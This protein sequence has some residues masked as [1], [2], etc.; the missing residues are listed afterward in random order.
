M[1][2][3]SFK[4]AMKDTQNRIKSNSRSLKVSMIW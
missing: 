1:S 2:K 3:V 4:D